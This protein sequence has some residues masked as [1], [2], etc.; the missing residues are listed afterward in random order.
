M[1]M[2][3]FTKRAFL[4][5]LCCM[6]VLLGYLGV[7][8]SM[9]PLMLES[10]LTNENFLPVFISIGGI[11]LCASIM[12]DEQKH[13]T[14]EKSEQ[15]ERGKFSA[16]QVI[17]IGD[18]FLFILLY[19]WIGII[20]ASFIFTSFFMVFFDDTI[21]HIARKL[22]FSAAITAIVYILYAVVFGVHF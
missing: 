13:S 8:L 3:D 2:H 16:K 11:Y 22:L 7:A 19:Y 5:P 1:K 20:S 10:G 6:V 17:L 4:I 18:L 21:C 14:T 15:S 9:G 12:Y